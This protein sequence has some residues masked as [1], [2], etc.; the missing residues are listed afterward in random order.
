MVSDLHAEVD[1]RARHEVVDL[2]ADLVILAGDAQWAEWR[3]K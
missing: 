2:A 1:P 3:L